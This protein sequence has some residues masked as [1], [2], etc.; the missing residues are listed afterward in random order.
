MSMTRER[1]GSVEKEDAGPKGNKMVYFYARVSTREQSLARQT[2]AAKHF[3]AV[4][5]VFCDKQSG[6]NFERENYTSLKQTVRAGDEVIVKELDRLGRNKEE[7][8]REIAWFKENGVTLRILDIPTTLIDFGGQEWIRDMVNNI[9]IEVLG[10]I[11]EQEREKTLTRQREGLDAMRIVDGKHYSDK[12]QR[13]CGRAPVAV[14]GFGEMLEKQRRGEISV[15]EG[16]K[17]LGISRS[18]WYNKAKE[19]A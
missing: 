7:V 3:R 9:L 10:A 13:F 4:D 12:K 14:D 5:K 16:C 18:T 1:S 8:K 11:A 6:K 2:E 15:S 17:A 19:C